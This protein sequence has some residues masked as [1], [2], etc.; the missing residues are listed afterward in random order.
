MAPKPKIIMRVVRVS[1]PEISFKRGPRI[2]VDLQEQA[3]PYRTRKL[4]LEGPSARGGH[5]R[6]QLGSDHE[7]EE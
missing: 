2:E 4:V 3:P 7:V 1:D 6:F 5:Q